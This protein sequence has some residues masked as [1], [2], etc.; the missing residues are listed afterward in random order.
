MTAAVIPFPRPRYATLARRL[1]TR[2]LRQKAG[3]DHVGAAETL[4]SLVEHL[5]LDLVEFQTPPLFEF[6][7]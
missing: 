3:G 6:P 4:A 7:A 2:A 1:L 5:G